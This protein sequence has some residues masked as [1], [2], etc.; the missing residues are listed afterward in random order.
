MSTW[1]PQQ[2]G[3]LRDVSAWLRDPSGKQIFRLFG[4]AG[5]GKT[6]LARE[7]AGQ[8]K[9]RVLFAAFTG[10]AAHVMRQKGCEGASTIHSL[11]YKLTDED[12]TGQ[13]RFALNPASDVAGAALVIVDEVSMVGEDLAK[14]LLSFNTPLLVL[15][16]PAQLP[17]VK[18]Q[19]F[20]TDAT[21]D[22]MLTEVHRQAEHSPIIRLATDIRLGK[23]LVLGGD[24]ECRVIK[25]KE[26]VGEVT[27]SHDQI[28]C[29]KNS[30][31]HSMN[32]R[33][34]ALKGI[35][36]LTPVLGEKLVCLKNDR[37][38][39]L[40]NGSLW[41]VHMVPKKQNKEAI[42]KE[43]FGFEVV[44]E[45]IETEAKGLSVM[46]KNEFW[47]G[48]EGELDYNDKRGTDEFTYGYALTTHKAQGSQ[49]DSV[50]V[51][52]EG[53]VFREDA[54]RWRYTA[55]TRAAKRLTMVVS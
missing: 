12:Y 29:G 34:R 32:A 54:W 49:W 42:L 38:K 52:D 51:F 37:L 45:D 27:L 8:V 55:I 9:G 41:R 20:F 13:P 30:T 47:N 40:M 43:C 18:G 25:W 6:T 17:P 24:D 53:S 50:I 14:D 4:Y 21:P 16:D 39:K 46:V 36:G 1:S 11:I 26:A 3:A 31:R 33:I 7:F 23:S 22:V 10:K 19:G 5:T 2:E 15:G 28:L 48:H 35:E 44:P